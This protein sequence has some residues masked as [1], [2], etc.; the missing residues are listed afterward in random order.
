MLVFFRSGTLS[1][2]PLWSVLISI[3]LQFVVLIVKERKLWCS[4]RNNHRTPPHAY[5]VGGVRHST[6][7][8]PLNFMTRRAIVTRPRFSYM[9]KPVRYMSKLP[10]VHTLPGN[11]FTF[12]STSPLSRATFQKSY[13][14][15]LQLSPEVVLLAFLRNRSQKFPDFL[16]EVKVS[17]N[18][19]SGGAGFF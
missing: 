3:Q 12:V 14:Q 9:P 7:L 1:R 10:I 2:I 17:S 19:K 16:H 5:L 4:K 13:R 8:Q 11:T 15:A 6:R 18:L